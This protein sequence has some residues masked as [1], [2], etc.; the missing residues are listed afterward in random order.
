[1]ALVVQ[2]KMTEAAV[3]KLKDMMEREGGVLQWVK[4]YTSDFALEKTEL[5]GFTHKPGQQ[6]QVIEIGGKMVELVMSHHFLG[7]IFDAELR[8]REQ[9][10]KVLCAA[11]KWAHLLGRVCCL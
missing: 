10:A 5:V 1:M 9:W 2:A 3:E 7:V 8:W 11:T 4:E 6:L